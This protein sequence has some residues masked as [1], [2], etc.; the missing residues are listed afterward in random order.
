M[1]HFGMNQHMLLRVSTSYQSK[2]PEDQQQM[3]MVYQQSDRSSILWSNQNN[4][5]MCKYDSYELNNH[6]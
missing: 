6:R 5:N 2:F 1:T 3:K 4:N